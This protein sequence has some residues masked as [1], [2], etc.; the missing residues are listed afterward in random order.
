MS[1]SRNTT[2][3]Y[4]S[5]VSNNLGSDW[6]LVYEWVNFLTVTLDSKI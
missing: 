1:T 3:A 5:N 6:H 4:S 2:L